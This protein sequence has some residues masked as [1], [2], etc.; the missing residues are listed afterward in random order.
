MV[1]ELLSIIWVQ[2]YITHGVYLNSKKHE[3]FTSD[4]ILA[5]W[6][7]YWSHV[8]YRW[9]Q[10][11]KLYKNCEVSTLAVGKISR[12]AT[13]RSP[14][15]V[16]VMVFELLSI[17]WV[18][19]YITHGVCLNSKK[20]E[21]LTSGPILANR[22]GQWAH[23]VYRWT[24]LIVLY[25]NFDVSTLADGK[26]SRVATRRSPDRSGTLTNQLPSMNWKQRYS[27]CGGWAWSKNPILATLGPVLTNFRVT[28]TLAFNT[29]NRS[30]S[31]I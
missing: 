30:F 31:G 11:I 17:I 5:I 4:P 24:Q 21:N 26:I 29:M 9:T 22:K 2:R 18:Q 27:T 1:F 7:G 28:W 6:R 12:V 23:V 20:H 13:R 15:R 8:V 25:K 10:L 14:D 19:R 3:N 16:V